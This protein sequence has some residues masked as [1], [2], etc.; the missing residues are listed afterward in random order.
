MMREEFEKL[1]GIYPTDALYKEIEREYMEFDGD[2]VAFV[3]AFK[4][5]KDGMAQR[6]QTRAIWA[7][8]ETEC[9]AEDKSLAHKAEL[10][11][12]RREIETL[13][14]AL[15]EEQGRRLEAQVQS[16]KLENAL[17][18]AKNLIAEALAA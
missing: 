8:V 9:V 11:T 6:C 7:K 14:N 15:K 2:K 18:N 4:K 16:R 17:R 12:L 5:N 3:K 1:S 13:R 10:E